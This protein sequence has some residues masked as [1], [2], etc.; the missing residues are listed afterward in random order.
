[1]AVSD[2]KNPYT[3]NENVEREGT[4]K[5]RIMGDGYVQRAKG[6]YFKEKKVGAS[7]HSATHLASWRPQESL[8]YEQG[9]I[10]Q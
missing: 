5:K 10:S 3:T 9:T 8:Q 1:M 7:K 2:D 6:N 4:A